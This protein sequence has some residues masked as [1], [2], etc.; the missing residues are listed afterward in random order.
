MLLGGEARSDLRV[1]AVE[2]WPQKRSASHSA[3]FVVRGS[4]DFMRAADKVRVGLSP[5]WLWLCLVTCLTAFSCSGLVGFN[6]I[7]QTVYVTE[8]PAVLY[9]LCRSARRVDPSNR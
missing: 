3:P 5:W 2:A 7:K 8:K 6:G 9:M 4:G 1:V